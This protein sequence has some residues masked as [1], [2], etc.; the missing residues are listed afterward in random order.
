MRECCGTVAQWPGKGAE[1]LQVSQRPTS[2]NGSV[3]VQRWLRHLDELDSGS[4]ASQAVNGG[5]L[6]NSMSREC[7]LGESQ[8]EERSDDSPYA[9]LLLCFIMHRTWTR[10]LGNED[11][12]RMIHEL[13][14][15]LPLRH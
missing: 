6:C 4:S 10:S 3:V 9:T 8:Q 15:K 1:P 7:L 5:Q 13:Q 11:R 12:S 14:E 2:A